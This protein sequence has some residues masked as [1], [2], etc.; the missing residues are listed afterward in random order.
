[1]DGWVVGDLV[2][3]AILTSNSI[4]VEVEAEHINFIFVHQSI[5]RLSVSV[6]TNSM[7]YNKTMCL[8]NH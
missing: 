7:V 8:A 1:M 3:K 4:E 6:S 2:S 5:A